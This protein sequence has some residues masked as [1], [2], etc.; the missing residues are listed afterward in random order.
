MPKQSGLAQNLY[1]GGYNLSGDIGS[2]SSVH[3]GNS[4]LP[5]TGIDK[6]AKERVGGQRDGELD[7]TAWFNPSAGQAHPVLSALPTADVIVTYCSAVTLGS[8]ACCQVSKQVNYDPK[9]SDNGS[10][11]F[12]TKAKANAFGQ[13][14]GFQLTAGLRTDTTATSPAT[15]VDTIDVTSSFGWQAYLQVITFA[16]TSVTMTIQDSADNSAFANL[17][18]GAFTAVTAAPATQRLVSASG[19]DTVRRYLKVNTTGTFSNAVFSVVF[20]RNLVAVTF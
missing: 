2:L 4:P 5:M 12:N 15:G 3:G 13:E 20:I 18:G 17:S 9:R 1:V 11:T 8:Q 7:F 6:S 16:G 19:T 14:W 10:L